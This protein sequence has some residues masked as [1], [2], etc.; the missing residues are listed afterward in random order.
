M[1]ID[2]NVI[3]GNFVK[4]QN[5]VSI[6]DGVEIEDYVFLGP[7]MTFT[8]DLYPRRL[9]KNMGFL[10]SMKKSVHCCKTFLFEKRCWEAVA[11]VNHR[12]SRRPVI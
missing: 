7:H 10:W 2:K 4:I 5:G 6:Y 12:P 1:C 8:N 11:R 3:I 9:V